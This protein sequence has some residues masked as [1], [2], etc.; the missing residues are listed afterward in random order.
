MARWTRFIARNRG[1]VLLAWLVVVVVAGGASAGLG[2]LLTNRFSVPGSD[3]EKGFDL[4]K[5]HFGKQGDGFTLVAQVPAARQG[6]PAL[7]REVQA[8]AL[9]GARAVRGGR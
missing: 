9:R 4:L 5:G 6:D 2:D 1:K 8:A 3:A 7:Q